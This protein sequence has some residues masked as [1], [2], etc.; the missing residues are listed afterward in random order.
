MRLSNPVDLSCL[1]VYYLE[2]FAKQSCMAHLVL[3]VW[4][5]NWNLASIDPQCLA[6]ILYVQLNWPG[7]FEIVECTDPDLSPSGEQHSLVFKNL[8]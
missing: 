1:V 5:G 4:P 2:A 8:V 7:S 6:A 3:H